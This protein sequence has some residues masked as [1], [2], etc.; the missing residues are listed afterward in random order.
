MRW[1][2]FAIERQLWFLVLDLIAVRKETGEEDK[3]LFE[4]SFFIGS[5]E[6]FISLVTCVIS[7]FEVRS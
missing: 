4:E 3:R 6:E 5:R 2:C 7:N 1:W